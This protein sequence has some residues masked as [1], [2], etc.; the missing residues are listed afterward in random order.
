MKRCHENLE[1]HETRPLEAPSAH[2]TQASASPH[3][4]H[5]PRCSMVGLPVRPSKPAPIYTDDS[6]DHQDMYMSSTQRGI[7]LMLL[8]MSPIMMD[9]GEVRHN[10][11]FFVAEIIR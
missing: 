11:H 10:F 1:K 2:Q 3:S 5:R 4:D 8:M 9:D 6:H 7:G